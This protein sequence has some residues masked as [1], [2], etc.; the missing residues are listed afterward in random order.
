M[1]YQT[2]DKCII[3]RWINVLSNLERSL[4]KHWKEVFQTLDKGIVKRL[5]KVLPNIGQR[6]CQTLDK[7]IAK[8]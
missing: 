5:A 2:L 8:R 3:K 7:G 6:Y 1:Y 4:F